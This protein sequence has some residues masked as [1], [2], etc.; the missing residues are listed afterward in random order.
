M[1]SLEPIFSCLKLCRLSGTRKSLD[2]NSHEAI[3][4]ATITRRKL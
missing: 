2:L 4:F 3:Y 1:R